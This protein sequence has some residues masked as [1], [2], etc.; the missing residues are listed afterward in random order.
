VFGK[1][2]IMGADGVQSLKEYNYAE[3]LLFTDHPNK[4]TLVKI[5]VKK[6]K[7]NVTELTNYTKLS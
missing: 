7:M 4:I 3:L 1:Q 2:R 6:T 5:C